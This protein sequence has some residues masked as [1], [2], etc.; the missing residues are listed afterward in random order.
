MKT[1]HELALELYRKDPGMSFAD[2]LAAHFA[3]GYVVATPKAFAMARPVRRDWTADRIA[4]PWA[5]EPL[6]SADCWFIWLLTGDLQA[7]ARWLPCRLPWIGF[8]R[9][10]GKAKF[11][12]AERLLKK[13]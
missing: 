11:V 6:E 13:V 12:A 1:P 2:D 9:R 4:N 5:V 10:G 8:A 7:A 3:R